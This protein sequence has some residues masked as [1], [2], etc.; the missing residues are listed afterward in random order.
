MFGV[1]TIEPHKVEDFYSGMHPIY[2]DPE[3]SPFLREL[4]AVSFRGGRC[5]ALR[6]SGVL[7]EED[8]NCVLQKTTFN[9][10]ATTELL[11]KYFPEIPSNDVAD[12]VEVLKKAVNE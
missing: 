6:G 1:F 10:E 12:A 5:V 7:L 2:T 11:E 3:F 8:E 9:V 4:Y